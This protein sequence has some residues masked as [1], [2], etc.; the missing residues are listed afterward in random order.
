MG[1]LLLFVVLEV[2]LGVL[3]RGKARVKPDCDRLAGVVIFHRDLAVT[4]LDGPEIGLQQF[5]VKPQAF[6]LLAL[7]KFLT[8]GGLLADC[9]VVEVVHR[10]IQL[11]ALLAQ[12]LGAVFGGVVIL[13]HL[14]V[15]G[16][17]NQYSGR[18]VLLR[19]EE[20]ELSGFEGSVRL[21]QP[22]R[23]RSAAGRVARAQVFERGGEGA[24]LVFG[25]I[26]GRKRGF[27]AEGLPAGFTQYHRPDAADRLAER[28]GDRQIF[29]AGVRND[30]GRADGEEIRLI[31]LRRQRIG[32]AGQQLTDFAVLKIDP[33]ERV[34]DAAVLDQHEVRIPAHELGGQRVDDKVAHLVGA[35]EVEKDDAVAGFAAQVDEPAAGQVF[36]QQHTEAGRG[37]R[38]FEALFG[39]ADPGRPAAGRQQQPVRIGAGAQRDEDFIPGGLEDFIN[40]CIQQG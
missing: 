34:D 2:F 12:S 13:E 25:Q 23:R 36:A 10:L 29:A 26:A 39:Q 28:L 27:A 7:G 14:A 21:G 15:G 18:T 40:L 35:A 37:E 20:A 5:A 31:R 3:V 19:G 8:P 16:I 22:H 9:T 30:G 1:G 38:V 32:Q 11:A 4:L 24:A 33:L 6:G 17:L